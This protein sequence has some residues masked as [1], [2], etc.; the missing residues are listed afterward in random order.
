M[1]QCRVRCVAV[2]PVIPNDRIVGH[3]S[4]LCIMVMRLV[5]RLGLFAKACGPSLRSF[6]NL[7]LR[8][9]LAPPHTG[10]LR[11]FAT[12]GHAEKKQHLCQTCGKGF[13]SPSEVIRYKRVSTGEKPYVCNLFRNRSLAAT[14]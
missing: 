4:N 9:V 10:P 12:L 1:H 5:L 11:S 8:S 3:F 6:A 14:S 13:L 7:H 2:A